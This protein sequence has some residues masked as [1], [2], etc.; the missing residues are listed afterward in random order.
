VPS[1]TGSTVLF[2][3]FPSLDA[4][5]LV[6][7]TQFREC[8]ERGIASGEPMLD[9]PD[10]TLTRAPTAQAPVGIWRM[11]A[12]NHREVARSARAFPSFESARLAVVELQVA[13]APLEIRTFHGPTSS[14]HGWAALSGGRAVLT[15][16]RWYE[17]ASVSHE[18]AAWSIAAFRSA[19]VAES[20]WPKG[21]TLRAGRSARLPVRTW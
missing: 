19:T 2:I 5:G 12:S 7:W 16:S 13:D 1:T 6:A 10:R 14:T 11:L 21:S 17:T 18:A 8:V 15:C 3:A 9:V 4:P 20:A